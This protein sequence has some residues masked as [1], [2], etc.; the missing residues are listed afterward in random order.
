MNPHRRLDLV[1]LVR[2]LT[3][4]T[5]HHELY[6]RKQR[7][8]HHVT[9]NPPL[10]VQLSAA[11]TPKASVESGTSRPAAS[12]PSAA[13]EAIDTLLRIDHYAAAWLRS[14]GEDDPGNVIQCVVRLGALAAQDHCIRSTP[15][16]NEI[17]WV[18][19]C[20]Y[21]Q[22]EADVRRWWTWARVVTRWDLPPWQPDNT[23][24]LCGNRGTLRVRIAER[25]AMCSEDACRETWD[26]TTI[27]L[28]ADHIR[29]E[30]HDTEVAS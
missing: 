3:Q 12:K 30:N 19:C 17:G 5:Q 6:M 27:G 28:L 10:L 2:E 21:H 13:I 8:R 7:P 15:R 23:C 26:E 14:L 29:A 16:R 24:P 22:I 18:V 11:S 1:D 9:T 20:R 4:T 25:L